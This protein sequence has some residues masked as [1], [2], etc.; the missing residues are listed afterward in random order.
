MNEM[1]GKVPNN[2]EGMEIV[3]M[4]RRMLK[5]SDSRY[6]LR[7]RGRKP[8]QGVSWR[9]HPYSLPLDKADVLALYL[10]DKEGSYCDQLY[11][12]HRRGREDGFRDGVNH[13]IGKIRGMLT[14]TEN[15]LHYYDDRKS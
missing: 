7:L 9:D 11:D 1:I 5:A 14:I 13:A 2:D 6:R 3:T 8:K 10:I 15:H 4:L 12:Y